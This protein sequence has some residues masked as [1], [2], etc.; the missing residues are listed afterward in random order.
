MHVACY[1][2]GLLVLS[3]PPPQV[4]V[5]EDFIYGCVVC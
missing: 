1:H 3:E 4:K 5:Q 2:I